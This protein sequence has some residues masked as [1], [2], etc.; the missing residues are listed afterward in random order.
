MNKMSAIIS[1]QQDHAHLLPRS[2]AAEH[3]F[4]VRSLRLRSVLVSGCSRRG[5]LLGVFRRRR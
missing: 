3:R 2:R 5:L 1:E 4:V